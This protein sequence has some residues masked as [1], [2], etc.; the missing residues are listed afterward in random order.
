MTNK[1][2]DIKDLNGNEVAMA[3]SG[4]VVNAS[5]IK[6]GQ[7][8]AQAMVLGT[9]LNSLLTPYLT[10]IST[11]VHPTGSPG[12]PTLVSPALAVPPSLSSALSTKH[13][14]E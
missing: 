8:A 1:G 6:L 13:L 4:T 14:V 5:Q 12:A 11:H 10:L 9:L 7:G 3:A 2:V